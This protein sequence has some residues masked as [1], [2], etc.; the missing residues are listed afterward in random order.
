VAGKG[1]PDVLQQKA[2]REGTAVA[3]SLR[4]EVSRRS[5]AAAVASSSAQNVEQLQ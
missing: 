2:Q 1:L 3:Q 5:S 4:D